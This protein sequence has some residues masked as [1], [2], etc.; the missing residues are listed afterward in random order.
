MKLIECANKVAEVGGQ[1]DGATKQ[2]LEALQNTLENTELL[3]RDWTSQVG[4]L[5]LFLFSLFPP[6]SLFLSFSHVL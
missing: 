5:P 3:R 6:L 1:D 4:T 2:Q